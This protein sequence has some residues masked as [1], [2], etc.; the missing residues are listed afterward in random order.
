MITLPRTLHILHGYRGCGFCYGCYVLR[1]SHGFYAVCHTHAAHAFTTV[2]VLRSTVLR[3]RY[4]YGSFWIRYTRGYA[5]LPA[6]HHARYVHGYHTLLP[7]TALRGYARLPLPFWIAVVGYI[8][9]CL[10][11]RTHVTVTQ[12]HYAHT[13]VVAVRSR[14]P[15]RVTLLRF[16]GYCYGYC[17]YT[18]WIHVGLRLRCRSRTTVLP[19]SFLQFN[20]YLWFTAVWLRYV[21]FTRLRLSAVPHRGYHTRLVTTHG[22]D[23][24]TFTFTVWLPTRSV[25]LLTGYARIRFVAHRVHAAR[26]PRLPVRTRVRCAFTPR[27]RCV[28]SLLHYHLVGSPHAFHTLRS[29]HGCYHVL[30]A[31][32]RAFWITVRLPVPGS[33]TTVLPAVTFVGSYHAPGLHVH[34]FTVP[35]FTVILRRLLFAVCHAHRGCYCACGYGCWVVPPLLV[36]LDTTHTVTRLRFTRSH[37]LPGCRGY[38][39]YA[40]TACGS[41]I[42]AVGFWLVLL[43][44]VYTHGYTR[45]RSTYAVVPVYLSGSGY[46]L[47]L[48]PR[49]YTPPAVATRFGWIPVYAFAPALLVLPFRW[50]PLLPA[51]LTGYAFGSTV[52]VLPLQFPVPYTTVCC[53]ADSCGSLRVAFT[54]TVSVL[55]RHYRTTP[56]HCRLR[57]VA[58]PLVRYIWL[59]APAVLTFCPVLYTR[60]THTYAVYARCLRTGSLPLRATAAIYR[61]LLPLFAVLPLPFTYTVRVV[62][63]YAVYTHWLPA[64]AHAAHARCHAF[65]AVTYTRLPTGCSLLF[66]GYYLV[67]GCGYRF[68]LPTFAFWLHYAH[69]VH[70]PLPCR[71]AHTDT[72]LPHYLGSRSLVACGSR[73][74]T[75]TTPRLLHGY[76]FTFTTTRLR[77][78]YAVACTVCRLRVAPSFWFVAGLL[79]SAHRLRYACLVT[80]VAVTAFGSTHVYARL[81]L[82]LLPFVP[83][84]PGYGYSPTTTRSP[85]PTAPLLHI[86]VTVLT[87]PVTAFAVVYIYLVAVTPHLLIAITQLRFLAWFT[88]YAIL[89]SA[90]YR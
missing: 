16:Y 69:H 74:Y 31:V 34:T 64:F 4:G 37:A 48:L 62:W 20:V 11:L 78:F 7:R 66:A 29:T 40:V 68:A 86:R 26:M 17:A 49:I 19:R 27:Y 35:Q 33:V 28:L 71:F 10:D 83:V 51:F 76:R 73:F 53:I 58:T 67:Y 25:W 80:A 2:A 18:I 6:Y 41:C 70:V 45:T 52:P 39:G 55:H 77:T 32:V 57:L 9:G 88:F 1:S 14:L 54:F 42:T 56:L 43:Y 15:H 61:Y 89:G 85:P 24:Y 47:I 46:V 75:V 30:V 59:P 72:F 3:L 90:V 13:Q 36:Y 63:V 60:A 82:R 81:L 23:C 44:T 5:L 50:L 65:T 12:L 38:R 8:Y 87:L 21:A 79:R 84:M 22:S